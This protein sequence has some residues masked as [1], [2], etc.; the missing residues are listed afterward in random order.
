[1]ALTYDDALGRLMELSRLG[2]KPG[3]TRTRALIDAL[4]VAPPEL[5]VTVAGTNG[6]GTVASLVAAALS[7][8]GVRTG[9]TLSP[10]VHA[11][12]ERIAVDGRPIPRQDV[13]AFVE[14]LPALVA[15]A[16]LREDRPT[17]F[18]AT[19]VMALAHFAAEGCGA[20]VLEVGL[21]GRLDAANAVDADVAV[22]AQVGR[23]HLD[24]LGP[25]L[26]DVAAE[27]AGILR[28]D[29]AAV[30]LAEG[31]ALDAI[32]ERATAVGARLSKPSRS[33][34]RVVDR[35]LDGWT[36]AL[37][38]TPIATRLHGDHQADNVL[39]AAAALQAAA[40][41]LAAGELDDGAPAGLADPD[42]LPDAWADV[43]LPARFEVV[44]PDPAAPFVADGAHN[45]D[46]AEALAR[47]WKGLGLDPAVVVLGALDDKDVEGIARALTPVAARVVACAPD[48]ARALP[49]EAVAER[50][51]AAGLAVEVARGVPEALEQAGAGRPRDRSVLATGSLF[52]AGEAIRHVTGRQGDPA[53]AL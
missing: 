6:K 45:P 49:P 7:A 38:G 26:A 46:A 1:M 44:E 24:L 15:R 36:F 20:W 30:T 40:D 28:S 53:V 11:F 18:E 17:F 19:T 14:D 39:L 48:Q 51:D 43:H 29:A 9:R 35:S 21:G 16:G 10:H 5:V 32:A 41:V 12:P 8:S 27:K 2:V 52:V 34:V 42:R 3:L 37:D 13:A 4:G 47:T 33:R 22:I 25:T 23:D 50:V 31:P